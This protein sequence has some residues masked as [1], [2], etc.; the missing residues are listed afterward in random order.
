MIARQ[1]VAALLT[2]VG[3]AG[4][5]AYFLVAPVAADKDMT[6]IFRDDFQILDREQWDILHEAAHNFIFF[7]AR[8]V[9][10]QN[11]VMAL[12][13]SMQCINGSLHRNVTFVQ[14]RSFA[15]K[16]GEVL[17]RFKSPRLSV[18]TA[19][20]SPEWSLR[21]NT[22]ALPHVLITS[23]PLLLDASVGYTA[24]SGKTVKYDQTYNSDE[25]LSRDYH[26]Q[27]LV[28]TQEGLELLM[29]G[30]R[31][32]NLTNPGVDS[33]PALG[34]ALYECLDPET[35][36][37]DACPG[38]SLQWSHEWLIDYIVVRQYRSKAQTIDVIQIKLGVAIPL[39]TG[40]AVI[41]LGLILLRRARQRRIKRPQSK[42]TL[43]AFSSSTPILTGFELT[44][45]AADVLQN[46]WVR[47]MEIPLAN[48][49]TTEIVLGR[50]ATSVVRKGV[51]EGLAGQPRPVEVGVKSARD[52]SDAEER[53]QLVKEL[54]IMTKVNCHPK[55]CPPDRCR[56]ERRTYT[57]C[58]ICKIR[59]PPTFTY[60]KFSALS[61][62]ITISVPMEPSF[63]TTRTKRK[64]SDLVA[65]RRQHH[66]A[67]M[68]SMDKSCLRDCWCNLLVKSVKE[69][70]ISARC[71]LSIAIWRLGTFLLMTASWQKYR[72]S[73][74][75]DKE[76]NAVSQTKRKRCRC[77]GCRRKP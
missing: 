41:L 31:I 28:W 3:W 47:A 8:N 57:D 74:W 68:N 30:R 22:I 44:A 7:D 43:V 24:P 34:I 6:E 40:A 59:L 32:L 48:L 69:C 39:A 9:R 12:R 53:R 46:E 50:G 65:K 16:Y 17:I 14:T 75:H 5:C 10:V 64:G 67:A 35:L 23:Y 58:G 37:A 70:S 55:Y 61:A 76:P 20:A 56:I 21:Y 42:L 54:E 73:E 77:G 63:H 19:Y 13:S 26:T 71:P 36:D 62:F 4:M 52:Q 25:D 66:L 45:E 38:P 60:S 29:D 1:D 11:G 33:W 27:R 72:I 49:Q 51:V 18:A 15:F 2:V